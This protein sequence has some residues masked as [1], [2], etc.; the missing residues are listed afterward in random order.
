MTPH[1]DVAVHCAEAILA[2]RPLHFPP[3]FHQ[4]LGADFRALVTA[5]H[6]LEIAA[7]PRD[8]DNPDETISTAANTCSAD[9][10]AQ[11][12]SV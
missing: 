1:A 4:A 2:A 8:R 7:F 10:I 11:G 6:M 5:T 9:S 3:V 12:L